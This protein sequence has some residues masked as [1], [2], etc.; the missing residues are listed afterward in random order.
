MKRVK[1]YVATNKVGS[2]VEEVM[3]VEDSITNEE[4]EELFKEWVW[5]NVDANFWEVD[6]KGKPL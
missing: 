6:E 3:E 4:L 1:F 2:K 5:N